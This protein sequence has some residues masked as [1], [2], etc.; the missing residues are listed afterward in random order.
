MKVKASKE[1]RAAFRRL[2]TL[3]LAGKQTTLSLDGRM[4]S[5]FNTD[6]RM[7]DDEEIFTIVAFQKNGPVKVVSEHGKHHSVPAH[8]VDYLGDL[9]SVR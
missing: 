9:L 5:K 2:I 4:K 8:M 7:I 1:E 6:T 3:Y